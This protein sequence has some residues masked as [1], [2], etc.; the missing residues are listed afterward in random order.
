MI[1]GEY[2]SNLAKGYIQTTII[3]KKYIINEFDENDFY[4]SLSALIHE[5]D[6]IVAHIGSKSYDDVIALINP[7][8]NL[9]TV[10]TALEEINQVLKE[11]FVENRDIRKTPIKVDKGALRSN[12]YTRITQERIYKKTDY[13]KQAKEQY[14]IGLKGE[15]L[16]LEI[17]RNRL[18]EM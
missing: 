10:T 8:E 3:S 9:E 5:Y 18:L 15:E 11:E 2:V 4:D 13:I 1:L 7:Q 17:E 6:E 16:A 12:K 14:Q